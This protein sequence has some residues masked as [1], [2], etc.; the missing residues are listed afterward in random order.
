MVRPPPA[1]GR[2]GLPL[3]RACGVTGERGVTACAR[4]LLGWK[5]RVPLRKNAKHRG[6]ASAQA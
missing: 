3:R 6:R 1:E 2:R 4:V 5:C